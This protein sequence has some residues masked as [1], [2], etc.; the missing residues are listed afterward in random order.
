LCR[1]TRYHAAARLGVALRSDL[2]IGL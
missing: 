1:L 2:E